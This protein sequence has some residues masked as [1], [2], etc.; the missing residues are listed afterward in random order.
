MRH[1]PDATVLDWF[2]RVWDEAGSGN[3]HEW[4]ERELGASVYS[5]STIVD[6]YF[7]HRQ[8]FVF[9]DVWAAAHPDLAVSL[10]HHG[11][12]WD[13]RCHRDHGIGECTPRGRQY[14]PAG[15]PGAGA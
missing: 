5:L 11:S 2:R 10:L 6:E 8:W 12:H 4:I 1:F 7:G 14:R 9:D 15:L 3:A 13:P